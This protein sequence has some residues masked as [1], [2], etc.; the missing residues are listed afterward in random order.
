[1]LMSFFKQTLLQ[2][3]SNSIEH[4]QVHKLCNFTLPALSTLV[5]FD[6]HAWPDG[7]C[8]PRF[9]F[10]QLYCGKLLQNYGKMSIRDTSRI[11][12]QRRR[13]EQQPCL[14]LGLMP[15][16]PPLPRTHGKHNLRRIE[17]FVI[18]LFLETHPAGGLR[19]GVWIPAGSLSLSPP[20]RVRLIVTDPSRFVPL[21]L[22]LLRGPPR[23]DSAAAD[24]GL[25]W[26]SIQ[27][28]GTKA[29]LTACQPAPTSSY[30]CT[31]TGRRCVLESGEQFCLSPNCFVPFFGSASP[32]LELGKP[33]FSRQCRG[34]PTPRQEQFGAS[35][36]ISS[37]GGA[38][39]EGGNKRYN[40]AA[41]ARRGETK[42]Q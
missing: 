24:G 40:R 30:T 37:C 35:A 4:L 19:G 33:G 28:L 13:K 12:N 16:A 9:P 5:A 25:V 2:Y 27:T 14:S 32:R 3:V 26:Q 10:A 23:G 8:S 31:V 15:L 29:G 22:L 20:F 7:K 17:S 38:V 18:S 41:S 6:G 34:E 42:A 11:N 1:M 36:G 39:A 21:L